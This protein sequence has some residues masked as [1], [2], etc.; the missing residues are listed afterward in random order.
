MK[1]RVKAGNSRSQQQQRVL[2]RWNSMQLVH[3]DLE[4]TPHPPLLVELKPVL[5]RLG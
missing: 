1:L 3:L 2:A 5:S 4:Q